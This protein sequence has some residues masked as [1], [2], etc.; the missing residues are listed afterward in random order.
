MIRAVY[1]AQSNR[2]AVIVTIHNVVAIRGKASL[3]NR[4]AL[5]MMAPRP[6]LQLRVSDNGATGTKATVELG[7]YRK[8]QNP[9][10]V[11]ASAPLTFRIV[12]STEKREGALKE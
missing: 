2:G 3:P 4:M 7:Q 9:F 11:F 8:K 1:P 12:K 10:A 6:R 5:I